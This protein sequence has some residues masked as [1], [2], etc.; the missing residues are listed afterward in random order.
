MTFLILRS[1]LGDMPY[2]PPTVAETACTLAAIVLVTIAAIVWIYRAPDSG[3]RAPE[4]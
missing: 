4:A 2:T 1:S 3:C